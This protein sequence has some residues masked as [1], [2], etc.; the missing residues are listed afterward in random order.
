MRFPLFLFIFL[1]SVSAWSS[2]ETADAPETLDQ[3]LAQLVSGDFVVTDSR[4]DHRPL[5]HVTRRLAK[6]IQEIIERQV[7]T[8]RF[9][10]R[11]Q[12]VLK[13]VI[14]GRCGIS[15]TSEDI[16]DNCFFAVHPDAE[17]AE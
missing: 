10:R 17:V 16:L 1:L 8:E 2:E 7:G 12:E 15:E 6:S 13:C 9:D 14:D 4:K 3:C 11:R 5:P